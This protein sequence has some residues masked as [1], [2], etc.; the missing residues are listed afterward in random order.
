VRFSK[1]VS[2]LVFLGAMVALAP[3]AHAQEKMA[4]GGGYQYL[5][6]SNSGASKDTNGFFVD[7]T[8]GLPQKTGPFSWAWIGELTG[9]YKD[10]HAYTYSG[11]GVGSWEMNPKVKPFVNIQIGG[12]T[13]G[14]GPTNA[15]SD[16][17][18][19]LWL[20]GGAKIPLTGQKFSILVKLDY[21]RAFYSNDHGGG[22]NL[23]R[24]GIGASLPLPLK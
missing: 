20:G 1:I 18:F 8:G 9:N 13:Q 17:A 12:I 10:G 3:S 6:L 22:Q 15:S 21:G 16:S 23:F 4:V 5:H 14:G 7:L 2:T 19:L 24:L 11:G